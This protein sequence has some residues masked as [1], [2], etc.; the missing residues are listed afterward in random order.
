LLYNNDYE[1]VISGIETP[2][3]QTI[4]KEAKKYGCLDRVHITGPIADADK[5]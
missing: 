3:K 5:A 1:L 2:H 4:I